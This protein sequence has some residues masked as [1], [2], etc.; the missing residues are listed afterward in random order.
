MPRDDAKTE[1]TTPTRIDRGRARLLAWRSH[2]PRD[3]FEDNTALRGLVAR[4]LGAERFAAARPALSSYGATVATDMPGLVERCGTDP[5]TPTLARYTAL[6]ER[7]EG[8]S[9]DPSYHQ[10][11]AH[12]YGSGV[13]GMTGQPDRA[14]EQAALVILTSH[15]GEAGHVCPL[16]CTA[17]MIRVLQQVAHPWLREAFLPAL[18]S[19]DYAQKLHGSQFLT[20][21]QGGSDVGANACVAREVVADGPDRPGQ[22]AISGEKWFCSVAD[23]PLY[24]MTARPDGAADGTRGLGLFLVPHELPS[25][26]HPRGVGA[27]LA[28]RFRLRRLKKK[29]GTRAMASAEIDFEGA[30]GWQVGPID[31]GFATVVNLVLNTS[32]IFNAMACAGSMWMAFHEA[33]GFARHREAFGGPIDRFKL[34][35]QSLGALYAEAVAASASTLDLV[36]IEAGHQPWAD[37]WRFGVNANK[38]WTSVRT[39]WSVRT[40]MEVMGGNGTIEDFSALPRL[41]RDA[42]VTESWEGTHNVL[43]A[44]IQRDMARYRVHEPFIAMLEERIDALAGDEA[45]RAHAAVLAGRLGVLRD[46]A[47]DL[48]ADPRDARAADVR[49]LLDDVM[50]VYQGVLMAELHRWQ[51]AHLGDQALGVEAALPLEVLSCWLDAHPLVEARAED[52]WWPREVYGA[53]TG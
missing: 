12:I 16:A 32:R 15:H 9:F 51:S 42:M 41:Y 5:H 20:E 45:T 2:A 40:A 43:T 7:V 22:W 30:L 31:R 27:G 28:N 3:F 10:L 19:P 49:R 48:A 14:I 4:Y 26:G 38:Y 23:A 25:D 33:A 35:R 46:V 18:T 11:G 6:G 47:A 24:L 53:G 13:M 1:T 34:V 8:V 37:A 52:G 39:T 29:L 50:V 17:G 44:Q 21:V 36:A